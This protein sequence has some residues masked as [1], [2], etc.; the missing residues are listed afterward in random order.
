MRV[1]V[2]AAV[3][4]SASLAQVDLTFATVRGIV[5]HGAKFSRMQLFHLDFTGTDFSGLQV[6]AEWFAWPSATVAVVAPRPDGD[7]R[8]MMKTM[9]PHL[10]LTDQLDGGEAPK[11]LYN[12]PNG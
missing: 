1:L 4:A 2:S 5:S 8:E 12:S 11:A 7:R 6:V 3:D 10:S 9:T